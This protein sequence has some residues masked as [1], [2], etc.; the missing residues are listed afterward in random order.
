MSGRMTPERRQ[1][2]WDLVGG[3]WYLTNTQ[4]REV[5]WELD[6]VTAERDAAR[7]DVERMEYMATADWMEIGVMCERIGGPAVEG[8]VNVLRRAIDVCRGE[9]DGTYA[10]PRSIESRISAERAP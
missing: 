9:P 10:A 4:A 5:L 2:L 3:C 8:D 1:K 7:V 6:A